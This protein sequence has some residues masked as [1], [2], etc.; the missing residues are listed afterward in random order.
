MSSYKKIKIALMNHG[1]DE[2]AVTVLIRE[3]QKE[4][5]TFSYENN[6]LYTI[7]NYINTNTKIEIGQN[8][9]ILNKINQLKEFCNMKTKDNMLLYYVYEKINGLENKIRDLENE[10]ENLREKIAKYDD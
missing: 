10:N 6:I 4:N 1:I 3:L 5:I 9:Y 8:G 2:A 7:D